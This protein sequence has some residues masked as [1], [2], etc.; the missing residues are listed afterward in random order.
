MSLLH[1]VRQLVCQQ[2]PA[3]SSAWCIL[4]RGEEDITSSGKGMCLE[5][6]CPAMRSV[7]GMDTHSAEV[8]VEAGFHEGASGRVNWLTATALMGD[9]VQRAPRTANRAMPLP[10][11]SGML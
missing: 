2:L 5:C 9:L 10:L 7:I 6:L 1:D 3:V 4:P 11:Y 8:L